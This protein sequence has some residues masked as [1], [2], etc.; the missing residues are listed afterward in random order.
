MVVH[1]LKEVIEVWKTHFETLSRGKQLSRFDDAHYNMVTEKVKCWYGG[2]DDDPFLNEPLSTNEVDKALKTLNKGKSPGFDGVSSEHLQY[3]GRNFLDL[4]TELFNRIIQIEHVPSNFKIGTQI[5]LYKGKNTC[6]LD[7]NNYRGITLLTSLNK[8][9]EIIIWHRIKDWWAG[10]RIISNLQGACKPGMSCIHSALTLQET[11]AVGLGA[12][13]KVFVAYFDV[14]KAFDSVWIDGLFY[15]IHQMGIKGRIWRLLYQTYQNFWCKTRV[16]GIYS[17]WYRMECGIHQG[18][19]LS[20]LKYT[21]FIDPLIRILEQS[22]YG[23]QVVGVPTSPVGYADDM[24]TCSLSKQKLDSALLL[25]S[26]YANRWR[27]SYNASK[28]AVMIYGES[29]K[30]F[31]HGSKNRCFKLCNERVKETE[32]YDHVGVKNCLFSNYKPRTDERI[33]KGRRA[34]NAIT[35]V[36]IKRKGIS[37]KVCSTLFW[38]IIAPIVTYGSE[39][40]VLRND[41]VEALRKFQRLVGRKCQRFP[42]NSPNYSAYIPIGWLSI[43]RFIQGKKLLF[44]RTILSLEDDAI[45]KR[46]LRDR[47]LEFSQNRNLARINEFD[48]PVFEILNVCV[49]MG[50][51]DTCMNMIHR[52]HY[53]SKEQWK[54]LVWSVVWGKED[55][56]CTILYKE[57]REIPNLLRIIDKPFYLIWWIISD[58]LPK[59]MSMCEKMAALVSDASLLKSN[60]VRLKRGSHW[61]KT[62]DRCMLGIKED[63]MHITMQCPF[64]EDTRREMYSEIEN[65]QCQ[66]INEALSDPQNT[67]TLILGKQPESI[68][69]ENMFSLCM[70]TGKYITRIYDSIIMR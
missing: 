24:A 31:K 11:I 9:F 23:C 46:I 3:T 18:G 57:S 38:T 33:S 1:D 52:N 26:E 37:M 27:Y 30:E 65:L 6:S 69:I 68:S 61:A 8:V 34:F 19:F 15:Q 17:D 40:W 51:F 13:K 14:A 59:H 49:E 56:D 47:S 10:E 22:R 48:S 67:F 60:D 55:E 58:K 20:L 44:L 70:I 21:A 42:P 54:K 41:E 4:L 39:V 29:K 66:Q 25:V 53:Y 64:Y 43:D 7:P 16:G 45:C 50:I 35:S 63:L 12:G 2:N 36:G 32:A 5:P 62:C 28:S